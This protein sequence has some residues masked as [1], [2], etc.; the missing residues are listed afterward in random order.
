MSGSSPSGTW[1]ETEKPPCLPHSQV[2]MGAGL[3]ERPHS[4]P[5]SQALMGAGLAGRPPSLRSKPQRARCAPSE[6]YDHSMLNIV[7][8][9]GNRSSCTNQLTGIHLS[10]AE[11][12]LSGHTSIYMVKHQI[13]TR[14]VHGSSAIAS[15]GCWS[16]SMHL[17]DPGG[18]R[19]SVSQ[20]WRPV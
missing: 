11:S 2:R 6:A 3:A 20:R 8:V 1:E 15:T 7:F 4:L 12:S 9:T 13:C 5:Y 10:P 18:V 17:S 19:N 14:V 16:P